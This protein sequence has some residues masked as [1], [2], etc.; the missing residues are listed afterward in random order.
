MGTQAEEE[1]DDD[2]EGGTEEEDVGEEEEEEEDGEEGDGG[3]NEDIKMSLRKSDA[4]HQLNHHHFPFLP[5]APL[6]PPLDPDLDLDL[7]VV[8]AFRFTYF[9]FWSRFFSECQT[10]LVDET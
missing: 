3:R 10:Y 7:D 9:A 6:G 2:E 8:G 5:P 1:E 4:V